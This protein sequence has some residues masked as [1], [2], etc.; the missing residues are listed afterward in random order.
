MKKPPDLTT[1]VPRAHSLIAA[2]RLL[3][4]S[5]ATLYRLSNESKVKFIRVGGRTLVADA[6]ISRILTEGA[7]DD[8]RGNAL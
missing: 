3:G 7:P 4:V 8:Q 2:G 5:R 1:V 6:E